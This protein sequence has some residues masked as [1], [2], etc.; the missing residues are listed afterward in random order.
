MNQKIEE[1]LTQIKRYNSQANFELIKK[2]YRLAKQAHAGQKRLSGEDF[3]AHPLAVIKTLADWRLDSG[4]IAA[5]LLHDTVEE[6][7]TSLA[8]IKK[9]FG[10]EIANL[11]DGVTKIGEIKL[12]G[13]KSE[14]FVENLRKMIVVMARD[15]R[16]V[17]IKLADR[18]HNLKTLY[19]L[20]KEK[21]IRIARETLEVYA[22]LAE[23]L[24]IGEMNGQL[25]DLAFPYFYPKKYQ[26]LKK[27]SQ[28]YFK[29]ADEHIK[30]VKRKIIKALAEK[31]IR[32]KVDGRKKHLYSLYKKLLRPEK[33]KDI[34]RIHDLVALR[35][36][37]ETV[38]ECYAALGVIHK[39]FKP[40]PSIGIR[41]FIAQPKPNGYQAIH[42]NVFC[43]GRITEIQIRTNKMHEHAENG[44]AAHWYYGQQKTKGRE[45]KAVEV[46]FFAPTEKMTWIKELVKWQE[47][48]TDSKEFVD[49]LRFDALSHRNFI[50]SPKGDV[51]DLPIDAT[52]VDFAYKVHTILGDSCSGAKVDGKLVS[53]HYKLRSGQ[54][55]E[56]ISSKI[57]KRPSRDWLNFVVTRT[58]KRRIEKH[59][60]KS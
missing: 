25:E 26:W 37:L 30:K 27:Y 33:D 8:K 11:V 40:V 2:A 50:F 7:E 38:E 57:K 4:S 43:L 44:I 48:I 20:P 45:D 12:R 16:V 55:V 58:A 13:K 19:V 31:S 23:R 5:G 15:L 17:L 22:P 9:E 36:I 14:A 42:T 6:S 10:D 59:F 49:S 18:Y 29:K 53:L 1:I 46:G 51:F 3:I 35:V 28:P 54:V 24:G 39:L 60:R 47:E 34:E 52:P 21:Q 32:A 56:I 41:D